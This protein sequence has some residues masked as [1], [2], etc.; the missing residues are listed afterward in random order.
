M[1]YQ[2]IHPTPFQNHS[3]RSLTLVSTVP[4][5]NPY[6]ESDISKQE[7]RKKVIVNSCVVLDKQSLPQAISRERPL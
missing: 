2:R 3:A 4:K 6:V 7:I 1:I 5:S